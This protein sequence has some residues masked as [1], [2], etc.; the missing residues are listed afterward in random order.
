MV[1][2]Y[3]GTFGW[4]TWAQHANFGTFGYDMGLYDQGSGCCPG[5]R[6]RS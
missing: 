5:S 2:V 4:L 1:A 3:V 6:T